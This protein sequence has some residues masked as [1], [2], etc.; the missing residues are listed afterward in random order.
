MAVIIVP[1]LKSP[2]D[3]VAQL[4]AAVLPDLCAVHGWLVRRLSV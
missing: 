4:A 1:D 2:S 3:E